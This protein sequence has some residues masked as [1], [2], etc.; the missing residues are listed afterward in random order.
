VIVDG[1]HSFAHLDF[2]LADLDCDYFGTS[3]HKW[4]TAPHG[5]GM[6]FVRRERIAGVW[7][8]MAADEKLDADIRKFEEI[9]THPA[10]PC[11]AIAEAVAFHQAIGQPRKLQRLVHLRDLWVAPL[12]EHPKVRLHTALGPGQAGGI[13]LF[14][15]EG[16]D[17]AELVK[18]LWERHRI[19]TTGIKHE[20]FE[21]IR[22]TPNVYTTPAEIGRFVDAVL[23]EAG[24][25]RREI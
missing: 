15:V 5:T 6:L 12:R 20:A 3:L 22:V 4:L 13:A 1:A 11:L 10:A 18:R 8:L 7:P 21:G 14:Q 16:L 19:F 9:G 25:A 23:A 2:T 24:P 17:S